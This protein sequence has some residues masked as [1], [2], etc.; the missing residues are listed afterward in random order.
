MRRQRKHIDMGRLREAM[1]GPD[2]DTRTWIATARVDDDVDAIRWDTALGWI[3][4]VTIYGGSL[5][6]EGPIACKLGGTFAQDGATRSD[7]PARGAEV[8]VA[9]P[10]GD[11]NAS[12]TIIARLHNQADAVP[13]TI[14]G[15]PITEVTALLAHILVS[16]LGLQQEYALAARLRALAW[17]I[18]G[19]SIA[20]AGTV[21]LGVAVLPDGSVVPPTQPMLRG[22]DFTG[23]TL[24]E[25]VAALTSFAAAVATAFGTIAI[26]APAG[27]APAATSITTI[28]LPAL[29]AALASFQAAAAAN[30]STKVAGE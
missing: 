10:A 4:D 12:P 16:P 21:A 6:Q 2:A 9:L 15:L 19:G 13:T 14:F 30:L 5:D 17:L 26:A 7:P 25:L 28:A 22:A 3:V 20:F 11:A 8:L 27:G 29:Q 24:G 23:A 1:R 18:E